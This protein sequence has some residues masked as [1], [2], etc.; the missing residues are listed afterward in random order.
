MREPIIRVRTA[1]TSTL[2]TVE[3]ATIRTLLRAA[4]AGDG[5]G[6]TE[7]DWAHT[8]GGLH[9]I[10]E[11]DGTIVSHAAV[12]ERVLETGGRTLR[13]G[14]VEGVATDPRHERRG[15]G[16]TVMRDVNSAIAASYEIGALSTASPGFYERLGWL[17]WTG[18]TLVGTPDGPVPTPDDD[19]GILVLPTRRV[20]GL[21]ATLPISCEWRP[22]DVW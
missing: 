14:Y 19:G 5:E 10:L 7:A 11:L 20:P 1:P 21:D 6:F 2:T 8:T 9:V 17:R 15:F 18:P 22:G 4:F 13:T 12:I 16:S 3:I